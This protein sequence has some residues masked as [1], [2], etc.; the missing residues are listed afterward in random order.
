VL[1]DTSSLADAPLGE[2]RSGSTTKGRSKG[3][4]RVAETSLTS[5]RPRVYA[6]LIPTGTALRQRFRAHT[7]S[8]P[9]EPDP[10]PFGPLS[11]SRHAPR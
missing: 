6:P 4:D 9:S 7:R 11:P 10:G 8:A 3:Y 5:D 2:Y 1:A